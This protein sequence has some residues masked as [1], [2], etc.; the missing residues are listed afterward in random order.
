VS[1]Q[2]QGSVRAVSGQEDFTIRGLVKKLVP[3]KL[4]TKNPDARNPDARNL[5]ARNFQ[6]TSL[7]SGCYQKKSKDFYKKKL[8]FYMYPANLQ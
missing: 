1:G 6:L 4:E 7:I 3:V 8:L 5:S 2:C